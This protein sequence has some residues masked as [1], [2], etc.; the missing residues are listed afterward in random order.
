MLCYSSHISCRVSVL[1][2]SLSFERKTL[3]GD[4]HV[5]EKNQI[6]KCAHFTQNAPKCA[7]FN[8]NAPKC[9]HFTQNALKYLIF[10]EKSH[11]PS[12]F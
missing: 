7:H 6:L 5:S 11:L 9:V 1:D 10:N 12:R 2:L 8:Q 3:L 4:S